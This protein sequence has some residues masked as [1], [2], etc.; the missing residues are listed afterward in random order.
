MET[1]SEVVVEV[2]VSPSITDRKTFPRAEVKEVRKTPPDQLAWEKIKGIELPKNSLEAADYTKLA[3]PLEEFLSTY[4]DSQH[5]PEVSKA[6]EMI[7]AEQQRVLAGDVKLEGQ[8][9][10]MVEVL[11]RGNEIAAK[12]SLL[13]MKSLAAGGDLPGALNEYKAIEKNYKNEAAYPEAVDLTRQVVLALQG[14]LARRKAD[15]ERYKAEFEQGLAVTPEH[16]K[17]GIINAARAQEA[18]YDAILAKAKQAGL[19]FPPLI[20]RSDKSLNELESGIIREASTLSRLDVAPMH[21]AVALVKRAEDAIA[22]GRL[23]EVGPLLDQAKQKWSEYAGI[24]RVE[25]QV[26]EARAAAEEAAAARE[27]E[28]VAREEAEK[29]AAEE[30]AAKAKREAEAAE[31]AEAE[32]SAT[33]DTATTAAA[34]KP[35]YMTVPG[36]IGIVVA[37]AVILLIVTLASK[38]SAAKKGSQ[39]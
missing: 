31:A 16:L 18:E 15:L 2:Q 36:A 38:A 11:K 29:A 27:A 25:A 30:A 22:S 4:P 28:R 33:E 14:E 3:A 17:P 12:K 39:E 26:E 20:P 7:K 32:K 13:R 21:A 35:F 5:A 1:E 37:L 10:P 8:W 34:E 24:A 6:L 19:E 23:A 9:I